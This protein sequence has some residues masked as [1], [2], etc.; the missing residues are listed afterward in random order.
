MAS[1]DL[2]DE[3]TSSICLTIY[4]DPVTLTCRHNFC[5]TSS[6]NVL[7]P[8]ERPGA[9]VCPECRV[10]FEQCPAL[11]KRRKLSNIVETSRSYH[12]EQ[13]D[14]G[15]LCTYCDSPVPAVK[16]CLLC[17]SSLCE[18]HIKKHS[19]SAEHVLMEPTASSKNRKCQIHKK[20]L[21]YYCLKDSTCV[22]V[23][24]CLIGE[25][26][27][28]QMESLQEASM[29]KQVKMHI[30]LGRLI[31]E[32]KETEKKIQSLQDE[33]RNEEALVAEL[34]AETTA[35]FMGIREQLE[36]LEKQVLSQIKRYGDTSSKNL[37]EITQLEKKME[38][39]SRQVGHIIGLCSTTDPLTILQVWKSAGVEDDE[40][41]DYDVDESDEGKIYLDEDD[42]DEEDEDDDD[43]DE[44]D[45]DDDDE[46]ENEDDEADDED[47]DESSVI[48]NSANEE[49]GLIFATLH[50]GLDEVVTWAK[51]QCNAEEAS[52]KYLNI[53]ITSNI[54]LDIKSAGNNTAI[55]GDGKAMTFS[56]IRQK[57]PQG[58]ERFKIPQV[59]STTGF[60]AG[61]HYWEVE[62][63]P[64]GE[65]R[66]GVT[67]PSI[68]RK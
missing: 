42:D 39:L 4:T 43:D 67:Y 47:D 1:A 13:E 36:T 51:R 44:E 53:D 21:E 15:I 40:N 24:C 33:N 34:T 11:E 2:R 25:H 23:S 63:S 20:V 52:E 29:K 65:W 28:H 38:E 57:R 45:E 50:T 18:K 5:R 8:N 10:E 58:P 41:D 56:N 31:S 59:L 32:K 54:L 17:E 7:D 68:I 66:V 30:A 35:L 16:T 12:P 14:M 64:S 22:C 37:H 48:K 62:G 55:S 3:L 49:Y 26:R 6:E 9:Y 61:D 46:E 19:K 60:P 27:G